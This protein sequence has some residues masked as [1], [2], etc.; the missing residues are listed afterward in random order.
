MPEEAEPPPA[1][2]QLPEEDP[3]VRQDR[4]LIK[5]TRESIEQGKQHFAES[6]DRLVD[7][8]KLLRRLKANPS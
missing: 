2:R 1:T 7:S 4:E 6:F 3:E 8:Q 5:K